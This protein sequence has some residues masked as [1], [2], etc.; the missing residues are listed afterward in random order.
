MRSEMASLQKLVPDRDALLLLAE[1]GLAAESASHWQWVGRRDSTSYGAVLARGEPMVVSDV[2]LWAPVA[3]T[4]ELRQYRL[5]GIRSVL[6]VPL[7]ARDGHLVGVMSTHW[8]AVHQPSER[9]LRLLGVLARQA[10]DLLE[11]TRVEEEA[12]EELRN[13]KILQDL[14]ARLVTE[15][16]IQ[17]IYDAILTA[18]IEITR[19]VAGTVQV[20]DPGTEELVILA[21]RGF[22]RATTD[23]FRRVDA[24]SSTSCGLALRTNDRAFLDFDPASADLS[25]RLHVEDGVRSAQS[26]PLVSRAGRP[27]GMVSTHWAEAG[28]RPSERELRFLD[29]L[30]RQAA[31]LIA[32][33][34]MSVSPARRPRAV[35][36]APPR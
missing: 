28:R 9:E 10:A 2:E 31:D 19:A 3:G 27:I 5:S 12:A 33:P 16:D 32:R 6:S 36:S 34:G 23:H 30:A 11:R 35:A 4:E 22:S 17:A 8:R 26:S 21:A 29:L 18:A 7:I 25:V 14:S 24:S 1:Q 15:D 20:L 13:T